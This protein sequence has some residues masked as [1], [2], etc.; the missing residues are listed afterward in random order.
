MIQ[1][2][3]RGLIRD[4]DQLAPFAAAEHDRLQQSYAVVTPVRDTRDNDRIVSE[5]TLDLRF[6]EPIQLPVAL[7]GEHDPAGRLSGALRLYFS[8]WPVTRSHLV[9]P[10][11]LRA[12]GELPL[13]EP[14][15]TYQRALAQG[16][17]DTI[18]AQFETDGYAREPSGGEF[19]YRGTERLRQF[20]ELLFGNGGGIE[21]EHCTVTDD[22]VACALEYNCVRWGRAH[23]PPQAG[24]AVYE[25]GS[26][27]LL[28]AARIYDDIEPPLGS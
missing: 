27:G 3:V 10:P 4:V 9:R 23:L 17:L 7:V 15:A 1:D 24:V 19:L 2:P 5:A 12:V 14:I 28:A 26:S 18:L 25:R 6:G 22:G 8:T 20:Y 13:S 11:L 16:D 21:L